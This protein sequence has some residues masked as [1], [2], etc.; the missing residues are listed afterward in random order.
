MAATPVSIWAHAIGHCNRI[1][2]Y[3]EMAVRQ[4]TYGRPG[5][6]YLDFPDDMITGSCDTDT[7]DPVPRCPDP[8]RTMAMPQDIEPALAVLQ[9][10]QRPLAPIG[11][12]M[13]SSPPPV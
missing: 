13:G 2:F 10:A 4:S 12:G 3:V 11:A 1:P 6:T 8:P 5:A 7:G 9:S